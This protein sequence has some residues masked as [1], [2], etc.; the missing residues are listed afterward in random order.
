MK[1]IP[2]IGL[3]VGAIIAM[4]ALKKRKRGGDEPSDTEGA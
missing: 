2:I 4:C 1:K 3:I